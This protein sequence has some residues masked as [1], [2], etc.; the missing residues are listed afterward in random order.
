MSNK[1]GL[2]IIREWA[3]DA[4]KTVNGPTLTYDSGYQRACVDLLSKITEVE[5]QLQSR[6]VGNVEEYLEGCKTVEKYL[7]LGL[8]E[9]GFQLHGEQKVI[10][11]RKF[12]NLFYALQALARD[13]DAECEN[14]IANVMKVSEQ[15][16]QNLNREINDLHKSMDELQVRNSHEMELSTRL[17]TEVKDLTAEVERLK[18]GGWISVEERLPEKSGK[19]LG[20][21]LWANTKTHLLHI[22]IKMIIVFIKYVHIGNHY[23]YRQTNNHEHRKNN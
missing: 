20:Y 22:L 19:Y 8:S 11:A 1:T 7:D 18:G 12:K 16:Q 15:V 4:I 3:E 21:K 14:R 6:P 2:Q 5:K 23:L 13:K 10:F 17:L 9:S